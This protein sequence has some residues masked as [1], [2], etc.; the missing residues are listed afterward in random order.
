MPKASPKGFILLGFGG[1]NE[2]LKLPLHEAVR[3]E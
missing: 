1:L 2:S 3:R